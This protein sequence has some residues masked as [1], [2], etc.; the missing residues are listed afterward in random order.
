MSGYRI[1]AAALVLAAAAGLSAFTSYGYD[2]YGYSGVSLGYSSGYYN[3]GYYPYYRSG[4]PYYRSGYSYPYYGWNDRFYYPGTGI[5]VYDVNRR[6]FRMT[7]SQQR[8][9]SDRRERAIRASPTRATIRENWSG[10][11]RGRAVRVERRS[12]R[13]DRRGS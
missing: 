6:P 5:Y 9:W 13:R 2:R 12:N 11:N 4:Y 3:S 7:T 8:F 1:R 10:F